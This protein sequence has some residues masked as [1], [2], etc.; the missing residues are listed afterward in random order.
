M[1]SMAYD[2]MHDSGIQTDDPTALVLGLVII[3]G[4]FIWA[5]WE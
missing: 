5:N 2:A 4:A 1:A 3:V